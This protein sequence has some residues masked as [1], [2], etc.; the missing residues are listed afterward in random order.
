MG[1]SQK[2]KKTKKKNKRQYWV[3]WYFCTKVYRVLPV[4]QQMTLSPQLG[5][6]EII[7]HWLFRPPLQELTFTKKR[8]H[9]SL[10]QSEI[11]MPFRLLPMLKVQRIVWLG[12]SLVR[13][14]DRISQ[15]LVN[16]MSPVKILILILSC[17]EHNKGSGKEVVNVACMDPLLC[18]L[19]HNHLHLH[20]CVEPSVLTITW[21]D[22]LHNDGSREMK[23]KENIVCQK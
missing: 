21:W 15:G 14:R 1:V 12:L 23:S 11:G 5:T 13:G 18:Q 22:W 20:L 7:I 3:D 9:S 4:F 6:V 2:K 19:Q 10:K 16:D 17:L 8:A